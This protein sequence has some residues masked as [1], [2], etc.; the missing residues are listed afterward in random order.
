MVPAGTLPCG[1][2]STA[3]IATSLL[4]HSS[5]GLAPPPVRTATGRNSAS[6][7]LKPIPDD[8]RTIVPDGTW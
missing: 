2:G 3:V 6:S 4:W 8:V 5:F 7:V 1:P